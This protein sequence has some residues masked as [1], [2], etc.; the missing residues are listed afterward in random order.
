MLT[1]NQINQCSATATRLL[2]SI[3]ILAAALLFTCISTQADGPARDKSTAKFE[4]K[5]MEGMIDHHFMAVQMA[6]NCLSKDLIHE[7]LR[8]L[9]P[10]IATAQ[11]QG[12]IN[13]YCLFFPFGGSW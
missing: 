5:F 11:S 6:N 2:V 9:C 8:T 3:S 10:N 7:D 4:I 1:R 13:L 12:T